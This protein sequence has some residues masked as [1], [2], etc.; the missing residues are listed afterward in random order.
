[1]PAPQLLQAV[2]PAIANWP[3]GHCAH[4]ATLVWPV[5]AE[6]V[7]AGHR[8]GAEAAGQY[9]P[10]GHVTVLELAPARPAAAAAGQKKPAEHGEQPAAPCALE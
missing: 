3:A 8:T 2:L 1:M 6:K 10:A 5:A 4:A 9:Q 7:P